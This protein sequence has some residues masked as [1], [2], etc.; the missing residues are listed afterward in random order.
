[1]NAVSRP[2]RVT[3]GAGEGSEG[4]A[5]HRAGADRRRSEARRLEDV[6]ARVELGV[7]PPIEADGLRHSALDHRRV[8][9]R[10]LTGTILTG[11]MGAGLIG[12]AIYSGLNKET[13][14]A[15]APEAAVSARNVVPSGPSVNPGKGDRLVRAVDIAA[16]RQNFKTPT[17]IKAGD[18]EIVRTQSFTKVSAQLALGS[19]GLADEVP[20]FNPL[21]LL[22]DAQ[23]PTG[24][25][26]AAP[27]PGPA[28]DAAEVSFVTKPMPPDAGP[29]GAELQ[30]D[31]AQAQIVEHV[32]NA[33]AAGNRAPLALP[34]QLLLMRTSHAGIDAGALSY[35]VPESDTRGLFSSI[36]VRMVP[37]NVTL[38]PKAPFL[39]R[40]QAPMERLVVVRHG[41]TLE[42]V[43]RAAGV[44]RDQIRAVVAAFGLRRGEAAV[45]E[46]RKLKLQ[47]TDYDG[48]GRDI[49]LAR[50][51]VYANDALE[52]AVAMT[53]NGA[54]TQAAKAPQPPKPALRPAVASAASE[55][56]LEDDA[57]GMR[58]YDSL[59]ETALKQEIPRPLIGEL[60]RIFAND[61]DFQRSV[62]AGDA[63]EAFYTDPEDGEGRPD[64]LY[65]SI[66]YRN[67]TFRYY[68][69]QT[70]DD[71]LVDYY[72]ETGKSNRKFL[73]RTPIANARPTSPYGYRYHPILGYRKFHSGTDLAAP[74]GTPIV[75][76][77]NGAV[78]KAA[79]DSGY[80]RRVEIQHANGYVTTY[81]H[82]SGFARGITEGVRVKQG[83]VIGY[84]GQT[85]LATGPHLHYEVLINGNFVDPMRVKLA[86][87]REFDGRQLADFKRERE[88]ID[89]LM[90]R[91][92]NAA[93]NVNVT[94]Q[95]FN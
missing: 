93:N 87:T 36:Q 85:G 74:I 50:L 37:E 65:A 22:A 59:Y 3:E 21:N 56:D 92:P 64:L 12:A 17:T 51:F 39:G 44:A 70:Q 91:A 33:I 53:D 61:V 8:S 79:W 95:R 46:G 45:S 94:A 66:T 55:D 47:F 13:V 82:M 62:S 73:I 27:D 10:W 30:P 84:L 77:G 2:A 67:E 18:K 76:A 20:E 60:V 23:N 28:F 72:D 49:R 83:Q 57:G 6:R 24:A 15:A 78:L 5:E 7:E 25:A 4:H 9:L 31:E 32:K 35:A 41:E 38:L 90:A 81:N 29:F 58:L 54:Y 14:V 89:G 86:R 75:A 11:V 40:T 80:G 68:R 42:D 88:R 16:S 26:A 1:M 52:S 71:N 19:F 69:F 48:S 43:L 34:P 63:I